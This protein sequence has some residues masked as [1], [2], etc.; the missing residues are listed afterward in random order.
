[1]KILYMGST[2]KY[3]KEC[4]LKNRAKF[5]QWFSSNVMARK[6]NNLVAYLPTDI[7]LYVLKIKLSYYYFR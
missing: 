1:M 4:I 7:F 3:N 5:L 2:T 6:I